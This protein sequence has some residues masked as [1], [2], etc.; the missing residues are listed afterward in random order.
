MDILAGYDS[1]SVA[2]TLLAWLGCNTYRPRSS[3]AVAYEISATCE[4]CFTRATL[5]ASESRTIAKKL[6]LEAVDVAFLK[7]CW[8]L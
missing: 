4:I 1:I 8:W 2:R 6:P 7:P 5:S 3:D